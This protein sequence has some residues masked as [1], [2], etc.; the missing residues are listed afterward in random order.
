VVPISLGLVM[1][2]S[3]YFDIERA[4]ERRESIAESDIEDEMLLSQTGGTSEVYRKGPQRKDFGMS[5]VRF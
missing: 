4:I 3:K 2:K 1:I 5:A